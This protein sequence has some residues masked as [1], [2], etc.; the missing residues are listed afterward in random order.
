MVLLKSFPCFVSAAANVT[1]GWSPVTD[2]SIAGYEVHYGTAS[3][4]YSQ[5]VTVG[6]TNSVTITNLIPGRTYYFAASSYDTAGIQSGLS[7]EARYTVPIQA[8][9]LKAAPLSNG[10]FGLSVA[11]GAGETYVVEASTDLIHWV[12]VATNTASFN[13]VDSQAGKYAQRFYRAVFQSPLQTPALA[14]IPAAARQFNV[15]V[16]GSAGQLYVVQ[17]S[18]NLVDWTSVATNAAPFT[19]VDTNAARFEKRFFRAQPYVP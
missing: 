2:P 15:A 19:F 14:A 4:T 18:T 10:S 7:N 17:A 11:G 12:P 8:A 3:R 16:A 1:L 5:V 13:F 6:N 9:S